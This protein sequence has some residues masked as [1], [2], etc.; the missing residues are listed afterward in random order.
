MDN[1]RCLR[2]LP[3]PTS[4]L[5]DPLGVGGF[6]DTQ[7]HPTSSEIRLQSRLPVTE[8]LLEQSFSI[9]NH[10]QSGEGPATYYT[11]V[12]SLFRGMNLML[13]KPMKDSGW[14]SIFDPS[15][16]LQRKPLRNLYGRGT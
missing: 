16:F 11:S 5:A 13:S 9:L 8:R 2:I 14:N 12:P 4:F 1:E 6:D 15:F 10:I 3:Q 7:Q